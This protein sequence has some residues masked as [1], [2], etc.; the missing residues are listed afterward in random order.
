MNENN[1]NARH[2]LMSIYA[3]S[4]ILKFPALGDEY[5]GCEWI[6][7]LGQGVPGHI[8]TPTP[9]YGYEDGDPYAQF[10]P[11]AIPVVDDEDPGLRAMVIVK[12]NTPKVGQEYICPLLVLSGSEYLA[13]SFQTL[14][15]RICD[16][17]RGNRPRLVAQLISGSETQLIFDDGTSRKVDDS[18]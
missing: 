6:N 5:P 9:G 18:E 3:T 2:D 14:Y 16:A 10:L 7:V 15:E 1:D 13:L 17:L 11:S 12:E 8:G 4:W